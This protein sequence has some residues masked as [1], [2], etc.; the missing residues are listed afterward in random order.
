MRR[1]A[2]GSVLVDIELKKIDELLSGGGIPGG[3]N[4]RYHAMEWGDDP[5]QK[6][7]APIPGYWRELDPAGNPLAK[8]A[9]PEQDQGPRSG[10]EYRRGAVQGSAGGQAVG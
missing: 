8:G 6:L 5:H 10:G 2:P 4:L 1:F 7:S 9:V 3:I